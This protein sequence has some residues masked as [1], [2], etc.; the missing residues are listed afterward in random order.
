MS[1]LAYALIASGV[2]LVVGAVT[3]YWSCRS[4]IKT[5]NMLLDGA[6]QHFKDATEVSNKRIDE[7]ERRTEFHQAELI[8]YIRSRPGVPSEVVTMQPPNGRDL[9]PGVCGGGE[10]ERRMAYAKNVDEARD[11]HEMTPEEHAWRI[12]QMQPD[13]V[14]VGNAIGR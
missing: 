9:G 5:L 1:E 2:A 12:A 7:A 13:R 11:R 8:K 6:N 10:G 4:T 14:R 3:G